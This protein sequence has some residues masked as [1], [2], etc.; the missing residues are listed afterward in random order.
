MRP[1]YLTIAFLLLCGFQV[2]LAT[3]IA[4][5]SVTIPGIKYV[6]DPGMVKVRTYDSSTGIE[7]LIIV[8]T[9][10]AQALQRW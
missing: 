5:T 1:I 4:E 10:K 7:P 6:I 8:K 2:I 9:S 3:N